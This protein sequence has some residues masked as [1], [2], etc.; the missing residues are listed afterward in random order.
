[1][2]YTI[3]ELKKRRTMTASKR[4]AD[5][6]ERLNAENTRVQEEQY[7]KALTDLPDRPACPPACRSGRAGR[8][9]GQRRLEEERDRA[10]RKRKAEMQNGGARQAELQR[11]TESAAKTALTG[12]VKGADKTAELPPKQ[13]SE[14]RADLGK[15]P[16]APLYKIEKALTYSDE[17]LAEARESVRQ[18][19]KK[20][21]ALGVGVNVLGSLAAPAGL[22]EVGSAFLQG[23][24][25][26]QNSV[27]FAG[28]HASEAATQ[29]LTEDLTGWPACR[30]AGR[31]PQPRLG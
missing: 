13:L 31:K 22:I 26:N 21:P 27:F 17:E 11:A 28:K 2:L 5:M 15:Q 9:A 8:Q 19:A 25:I 23:R 7:E 6:R 30:Q 12:A 3:E 20:Y 1:M 24:D 18:F 29:G 10:E 14:Y 4:A 16:E